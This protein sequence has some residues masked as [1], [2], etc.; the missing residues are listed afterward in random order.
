MSALAGCL[1][2]RS[3][4][5]DRFWRAVPVLKPLELERKVI[6]AQQSHYAD[7]TAYD[8]DA[9]AAVLGYGIGIGEGGAGGGT[10]AAF[11]GMTDA[12]NSAATETATTDLRSITEP[13]VFLPASKPETRLPCAAI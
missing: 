3:V 11:E 7:E 12:V 5:T 2:A 4:T 13:L 1:P 6:D 8:K 10:T 9:A